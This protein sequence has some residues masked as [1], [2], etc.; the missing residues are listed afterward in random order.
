MKLNESSPVLNCWKAEIGKGK[1]IMKT[2]QY[3]EE[4]SLYGLR[5]HIN[6]Y[7]CCFVSANFCPIFPK[8]HQ[9]VLQGYH[10]HPPILNIRWKI[11]QADRRSRVDTGRRLLSW[12]M[13]PFNS[14]SITMH[15]Q[16]QGHEKVGH[17]P[18]GRAP[19]TLIFNMLSKSSLF[20]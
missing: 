13:A 15:H 11:F 12:T 20:C 16:K 9:N 4:T 14:A 18:S 8:R 1:G 7:P 19:V 10:S 2:N 6:N 3:L 17:Q 5:L